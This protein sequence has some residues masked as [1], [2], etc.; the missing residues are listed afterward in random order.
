MGLR[1][2]TKLSRSELIKLKGSN[3]STEVGSELRHLKSQEAIAMTTSRESET[4]KCTLTLPFN[5]RALEA[6]TCVH[7]AVIPNTSGV[8]V[9]KVNCLL[10]ALS[11]AMRDQVVALKHLR[12]FNPHIG[13]EY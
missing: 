10:S 2:L 9:A 12:E 5:P 13:E 6:R 1:W 11:E 4:E 8:G 3:E 7:L